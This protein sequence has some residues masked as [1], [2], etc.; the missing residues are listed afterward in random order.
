MSV[1]VI[2]TIGSSGREYS[3]IQA[4]EDA[5]PTNL[6]TTRSNNIAAGATNQII[7][8]DAGAS[9][10]DN[11]YTGHALTISGE[12]RLITNYVGLTK[13]ATVGSLNGSS[14]TYSGAP[15][16]GT[17]YVVETAIHVGQCY[18]D[19]EFTEDIIISGQTTDSSTTITLTP[20][21]G[22][23]FSD[24]AGAS[25]NPLKYDQSKGVAIKGDG[26]DNT[27]NIISG[28]V[29]IY[30][31]QFKQIN[32]LGSYTLKTDNA[33][34]SVVKNC[35]IETLDFT[36]FG[37]TS[38]NNV[39]IQRGSGQTFGAYAANLATAIN[40]TFVTPSDIGVKPTTAIAQNGSVGTF[41]NCAFFGA[42]ALNDDAGGAPTYTTCYTDASSPPSGV[43]QVTYNNTQFVDTTSDWRI[44]S[45]SALK[46]TGTTDA[47]NASTDIIGTSRPQSS[48]YDVGCWEALAT[49]VTVTPSI[50][51]VTSSV[52]HSTF[53]NVGLPRFYNRFK[54]NLYSGMADFSNSGAHAV[55]VALLNSNY[56]FDPDHNIFSQISTLYE[57]SGAGY[58]SGGQSLT[59]F[60]VVQNNT[61]DLGVFTAS[62]VS[63]TSSSFG[64]RYVVI[65]DNTLIN[66]DLILCIDLG[67]TLTVQNSTF[68]LT[69]AT[70]GLIAI[71]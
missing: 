55:K 4:W 7:I 47:I 42:T 63:W 27:L 57:I 32:A 64:A 40:C 35:I 61:N 14:A 22:Q 66:K 46:D 67:A 9:G 6:T 38:I 30:G 49:G 23:G 28:D 5:L 25:T 59:G 39:V 70:D 36:M 33:L 16:V 1:T 24:A 44:P 20:A 65:Y 11:V 50:L 45:S 60:S 3:T 52:L 26:F 31:L 71:Q 53:T 18:N 68:A 41:V 2:H 21:T 58:S 54:K 56:T 34:R 37:R 51:T 19:S 13:T 48:A 69:W 43:T 29:I 15:S 17:A 12:S 8:L 62:N 10:S